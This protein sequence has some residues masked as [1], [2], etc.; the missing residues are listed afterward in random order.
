M[1]T[2]LVFDTWKK[3]NTD[4]GSEVAK[5]AACGLES[6]YIAEWDDLRSG[7]FEPESLFFGS[8]ELDENEERELR[9]GI[10]KGYTPCFKVVI[11]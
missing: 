10:A 7:A 1:K 4:L 8:I 3:G 5:D 9:E 2:R 6:K 11:K